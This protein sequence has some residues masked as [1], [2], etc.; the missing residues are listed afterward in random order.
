MTTAILLASLAPAAGTGSAGVIWL[1]RL[2]LRYRAGTAGR[3]GTP[4]SRARPGG[5]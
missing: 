1:A 5:A 4:K 2:W 3:D